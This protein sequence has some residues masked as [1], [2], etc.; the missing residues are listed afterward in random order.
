M[1]TSGCTPSLMAQLLAPFQHTC[2]VSLLSW[3]LTVEQ[4]DSFLTSARGDTHTHDT[5]PQ[6]LTTPHIQTTIVLP[7]H[8]VRVFLITCSL[9][10]TDPFHQLNGR[11]C[12]QSN[13]LP[14][15]RGLPE[16]LHHC[17]QIHMC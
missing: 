17:V 4:D 13:L 16:L 1:A 9:D 3:F 10:Y 11:R 5:L 2:I 6:V 7:F 12:E 8:S 15:N 14:S